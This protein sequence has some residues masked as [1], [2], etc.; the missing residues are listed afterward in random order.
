MR[1]DEL[2]TVKN[3]IASSGLTIE[4]SKQFYHIPYLRPAST[5][6]RTLSGW[7]WL[8]DI[9]EESFLFLESKQKYHC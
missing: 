2:F 7:V 1:L 6:Q 4:S 5:Q 3:G 8:R 9:Q